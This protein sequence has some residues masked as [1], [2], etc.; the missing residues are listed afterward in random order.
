M[1]KIN[2]ISL[3]AIAS[4]FDYRDIPFSR[5]YPVSGPFPESF[6]QDISKLPI[7]YQ[8]KIGSCTGQAAGKIKQDM[9]YQETGKI[10]DISP[11]FVYGMSRKEDGLPAGIEGT[12]LREPFKIMNNYGCMTE[13]WVPN[14][15]DLSHADYIDID[16]LNLPPEAWEEAKIYKIKSYARIG[17]FRN[18]S[19]NE[20]KSAIMTNRLVKVGLDVGSEWWTDRNGNPSW[21][22]VDILPLRK[23]VS[24]VSGH[25]VVIYGWDTVMGRTRFFLINSWSKDWGEDGKGNFFFDEYKDNFVEAW[26]AVDLPNSWVDE[27]KDLPPAYKFSYSFNNDMSYGET[28]I[29]VKNLQIAL[30]I[31]GCFPLGQ[32]ET[33]WYGPIT[34]LAVKTFQKKY[35]VA[36]AWDLFVVNGK[37]VGPKTRTKLNFLFRT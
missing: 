36:S 12:Y 20:L 11:R 19:I 26:V 37:K 34:Q 22:P 30:K 7:W 17:S 8:K 21:H 33:G 4:P 3:G 14:N 28:S 27:V 35:S 31:N 2:P 5:A 24:I 10:I 15:C 1:D 32:K 16:S 25:D 9:E 18:V 29:N 13:K 23:P 6:L